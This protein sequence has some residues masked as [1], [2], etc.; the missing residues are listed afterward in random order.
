M[1]KVS[2]YGGLGNQMFQYALCIAL[3]K[4]GK[5][6]RISF[7]NFLFEYH[8]S[9]FNLGIAFMLQLPFHLKL[10]NYFLSN[11]KVLYKNRYAAFISR[12]LVQYYHRKHFNTYR[13]GK[14][15]IYD[16]NVFHQQSSFLVGVWQVESY[17]CDFKKAVSDEFIFRK[18]TDRQ[19]IE[20]AKNI[21]NSNSVS[22]HIRRGDYDSAYWK[23][24]F[25]F[26]NDTGY[27]VNALDYIQK[28]VE[29]PKFFIFS[30][31]MEWVKANFKV[32]NCVYID[33]NKGNRSYIDMYLMSL[34]KHNIIANSTFSWWGAWLNKNENKI[35]VMPEKW[36][37]RDYWPE[38]I[39]PG[40]WVKINVEHK[41]NQ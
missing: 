7:S 3:N 26:I 37:K 35:V 9:G 6:T 15:F 28:K 39:F 31:D 1:N 14:E 11:A 16:H 8:H 13:E 40:E 33:H 34:C 38:G 41:N 23:N 21:S 10:L 5:K 30:D 12:K 18:P 29:N 2:V 36:I 17:F 32:S 19:N 22:I 27:Y 24:I 25:G 20:V 4:N